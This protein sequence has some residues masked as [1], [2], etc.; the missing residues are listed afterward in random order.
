MIILGKG[1]AVFLGIVGCAYCI[2]LLRDCWQQAR[3]VG[4]STAPTT[5]IRRD[6]PSTRVEWLCQMVLAL[7][8]IWGFATVVMAF[9]ADVLPV[10]LAST[11]ES[12]R[13]VNH[14]LERFVTVTDS[15]AY[16]YRSS[17]VDGHPI[18]GIDCAYLQLSKKQ[19][20]SL[21][22]QAPELSWLNLSWSSVTGDILG[23]VT[24]PPRLE[25]L[26]LVSPAL[27]DG[28]L[29]HVKRLV[30]L[31]SLELDET[32]ITDDGLVHLEGLTNLRRLCLNGTGITDE[33]LEHLEGLT[34]LEYLDLE[35]TRVTDAGVA[36]LLRS[37]PRCMIDH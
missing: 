31:S 17:C 6:A 8:A 15:G 26:A 5:S 22:Q 37:H 14:D 3:S 11:S 21:L 12:Y 34:E 23:R 35:N 9:G 20:A 24:F 7:A 18:V 27:T 4:K 30:V 28:D 13:P 16:V 25:A 10:V 2:W 33:G 36:K 32:Q 19:F 29:A 1:I